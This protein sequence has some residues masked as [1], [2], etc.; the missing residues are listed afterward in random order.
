MAD[1]TPHLSHPNYRPD[2]DGLRA[3]AVIAVVAFHAFP[4]KIKGGFIGV[5]VFFVISGYLISTIL[6]ENLDRGTFSFG[7]FYSRRIRRIFPSLILIL[8]A[9]FTFGWF[10]L[11]TDEY[12]QLGKYIAAG[13][14][15]VSNLVLWND[16]GYFDNL[17]DTKPLLHL[18]S[19]GIEEQFYIIWPVLLWIAWKRKFNLLTVTILFALVS[20][21][22]NINQIKQDPIATFYSPQTRFWELLSGSLLAWGSLYKKSSHHEARLKLD[23]WLI[24]V[25]YRKGPNANGSKLANVQSAIG[26]SLLAYGFWRINKNVGF[27]GGWA[28][29]PVVGSCLIIKAGPKAWLNRSILSNKIAI[30]FG[31]ISFPLY[32]WH[33]PLLSFAR[34]IQGEIPSIA[35][36]LSAVA[37]SIFFALITYQFIERPLRFGFNGRKKVVFLILLLTT[38]GVTGYFTFANNGFPSRRSATLSIEH[39]GDTGH[40]EYHKYIADNFYTCQ[41]KP[42]AEQALRWDTFIRCMQSKQTEKIDLVLIGDSHA[43][44]LFLGVSQ[45]LPDKNVAFYIKGSA[46]LINNP[47]FS[48]IFHSVIDSNSIK[49]VILTMHWSGRTAQL[50]DILNTIDALTESGKS[51]YLTD[52]VPVFPF[53]PE[54]CKGQRVLGPKPRCKM[55]IYEAERQRNTYISLLEQVTKARPKV[56]FLKISDY[57]CNNEVCSMAKSDKL[58]YRD[59]NHLNLYGSQYVG[60]RLVEDNPSSFQR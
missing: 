42:I 2:I 35:I 23:G 27:P 55:P 38:I 31:L 57:L 13:A 21:T 5:D 52:D 19:L 4:E 39:N 47:D 18:W 26:F 51:V 25:L 6:F 17:A 15:F 20:L 33:W 37:L 49:D 12:K 16:A 50:Q 34:I 1:S 46:P 9:C 59:N 56:S 3:V 30:W 40:L 43:E 53:Q 29:I 41:P 54:L 44:H 28:L 14:G 32:L 24:S 10:L 60:R 58:L 36:R 8:L 45:A 22:L 7:E 48:N 11:L